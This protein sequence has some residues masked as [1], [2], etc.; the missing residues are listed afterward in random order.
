MQWYQMMQMMQPY[1]MCPQA[2][3]GNPYAMQAPPY[4]Y[5]GQPMPSYGG[6]PMMQPQYGY[7]YPGMNNFWAPGMAM[8]PQ[9]MG[10]H[11]YQGAMP[12]HNPMPHGHPVQQGNPPQGVQG[13]QTSMPMMGHPMVGKPMMGWVDIP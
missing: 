1:G 7:G 8:H 4:G 11:P 3:M 6:M 12:Y 9:M 13:Q 5:A 10:M 2:C